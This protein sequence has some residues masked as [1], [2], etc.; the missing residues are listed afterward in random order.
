ME[1]L[2]MANVM[3]FSVY[4]PAHSNSQRLI[5]AAAMVRNE[6]AA[7]SVRVA[8]IMFL[9]IFSY[10]INFIYLFIY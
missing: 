3:A 2:E 1:C 7:I 10:S 8:F 5:K 9:H 6:Y 4:G